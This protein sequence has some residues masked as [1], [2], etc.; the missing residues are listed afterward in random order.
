MPEEEFEHEERHADMLAEMVRLAMRHMGEDRHVIAIPGTQ[1]SIGDVLNGAI[2][3][4]EER[5][6]GVRR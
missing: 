2:A 4:H 5:R 1:I 3:R 6:H